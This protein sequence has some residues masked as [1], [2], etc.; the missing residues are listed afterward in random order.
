[1]RHAAASVMLALAIFVVSAVWLQFAR[2]D[3]DWVRDTLSLYLHGAYGLWLRV[4]YC[5]LAVAI[6]VLGWAL[7]ARMQG[8]ARRGLP[9]VL[10]SAAGLGLTGVAV[11]DSWLHVHAPL[12][13]PLVH[14]LS[15]QT[16]FLCASV[17]LLLQAWC[18][19]QDARWR[20]LY[21][22][23]WPWAWLVFAA[24]WLHVLWRAS[25][26]GLGQKVV[27]ALVVGWLMWVAAALWRRSRGDNA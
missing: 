7:H 5:V 14:A 9:P 26:R 8:R 23:A 4:A 24:L 10:F 25:P 11:G 21:R 27:I 15:A 18:F 12:L 2:G 6:V 17:G 1:M 22:V 19:G 16:A 20:S 3:L 13:A